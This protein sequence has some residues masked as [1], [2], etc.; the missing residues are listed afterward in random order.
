M[1]ANRFE[2]AYCGRIAA[3]PTAFGLTP[4]EDGLMLTAECGQKPDTANVSSLG[5]TCDLKAMGS[6]SHC[7][8]RSQ[9]SIL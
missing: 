9:T 4:S 1:L 7:D 8:S 5:F 2:S 3:Q 6:V